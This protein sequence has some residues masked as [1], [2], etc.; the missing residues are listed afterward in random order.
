[1]QSHN[2]LAL[3]SHVSEKMLITPWNFHYYNDG[4]TWIF[5]FNPSV[6]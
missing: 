2:D 4:N 3:N 6:S 1:M 5:I